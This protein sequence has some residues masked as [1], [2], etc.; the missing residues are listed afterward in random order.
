MKIDYLG[1]SLACLAALLVTV[2]LLLPLGCNQ[3]KYATAPTAA[4]VTSG[5]SKRP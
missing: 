1:I 3:G 5:T 4:P 2:W